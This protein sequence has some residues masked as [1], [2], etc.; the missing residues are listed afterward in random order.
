ML[1]AY[2]IALLLLL[3]LLIVVVVVVVVVIVVVSVI[4]HDLVGHRSSLS[5]KRI[6][7]YPIS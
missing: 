5:L 3:L 7:Y 1:L 6:A 4:L 2:R